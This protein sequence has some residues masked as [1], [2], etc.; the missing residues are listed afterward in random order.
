[1]GYKN[2]LVWKKADLLAQK[3]YAATVNFPKEE[4]FGLRSQ[5]RRS[6]VSVP[7]NLVEG[8]GRQNKKETRSFANIALGSLSET[9]YLLSL[10]LQLGYLSSAD[11]E[12]LEKLRKEVGGLLWLFYK[13]F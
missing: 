10:C 2:L 3:V 6:A 11:Y 9:E 12:N 8:C 1:M 7:I 4:T 5:I 13:S